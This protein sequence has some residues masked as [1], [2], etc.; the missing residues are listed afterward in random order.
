M[1]EELGWLDTNIFVHALFPNDPYYRRCKAIV[2]GLESGEVV[3]WLDPVIVHE[4]SYVLR[5]LPM[6]KDK[7]DIH[8]YLRSIV[9]CDNVFMDDKQAVI[10]ALV[11]WE[12]MEGLSFADAWLTALSHQRSARTVC[13]VNQSDFAGVP[14]TFLKTSPLTSA[15][16]ARSSG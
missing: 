15:Y 10:E 12:A 4:L 13:S 14:N 1:T 2:D 3:G 7:R 6:F 16:I 8:Q 9:L 11:R 5:R